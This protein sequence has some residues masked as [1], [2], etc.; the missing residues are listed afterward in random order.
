M[1][2]IN[3]DIVDPQSGNTVIVNGIELRSL[4]GG[5]GTVNKY[6]GTTAPTS[7]TA[8][9]N[10]M[11]GSGGSGISTGNRNTV[12][13]LFSG[14]SITTGN[15]NVAIG[16]GVLT[17]TLVGSDNIAIGR[18]SLGQVTNPFGEVAIGHLALQA[19]TTATFG[20]NTAVGH[21][22]LW[23]NLT[24]GA[25]TALGVEAGAYITTGSDNTFLG[26]YSGVSATTGTNNICIGLSSTTTTPTTSNS[27]TLG[28]SSNNVLRCAVTSITSLS[29]ARD[30]E[31]VAELAVGLEFVKE[32]NPVSFVWNDRDESGKH[33]VKDFGFIAQ[34]LK[35]T[36]E[37]YEMAETL[38]L[39]Y[40]ENPE[41]LEASYGKLIPILVQAIKELSAK[42]E[43]LE[44]K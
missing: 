39:V 24:G 26:S 28:N 10:L 13:G 18:N 25:N 11:V 41:K 38:G 23:Q 16:T 17:N 43:A 37:K 20:P 34:D 9:A 36:Q 21:R 12:L 29:D 6:I 4:A 35:S 8:N 14:N 3:V 5:P 15:D 22:A 2:T 42:V 27:I 44:N 31:E 1:S 30:K 32:L 7:L 33:G 40:E 19:F